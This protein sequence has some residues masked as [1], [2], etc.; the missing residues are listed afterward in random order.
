MAGHRL[1]IRSRPAEVIRH[2]PPDVKRA[3]RSALRA[4][5]ADP[6][7]GDRLHAELEGLWKYRVRRFRLVYRVDRK[8]KLIDVVAVGERR[9]IYEEVAELL[10][11]NE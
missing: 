8:S 9:G 2:L 10:R 7:V 1:A 6:A 3:V 4:L 5:A 11:E